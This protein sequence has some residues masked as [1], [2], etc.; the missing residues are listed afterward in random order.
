M[1]GGASEADRELQPN[2]GPAASGLAGSKRD[3]AEAVLEKRREKAKKAKEAAE[4]AQ[5]KAW[6]DLK[7]NTS[8]YVTGLPDDVTEM[9]LAQVCLDFMTPQDS[10][11][12]TGS[13]VHWV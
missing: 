7:I 4:A 9:E 11:V 6:F 5:P 1:Q 12:C 2:L 10:A 8:V 13:S 3:A